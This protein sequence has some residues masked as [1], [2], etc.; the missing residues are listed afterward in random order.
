MRIEQVYCTHCTYGTSALEQR[1][2]ELADRVLGYSARAGSLERND[3]RNDYRAIERFLYYYLPSDT[4]PDEKQRLDAANA[5]RRLFFC[6]AMGKLQMVGQVAY[7][8][9]DTAG[10]LGSYFA[11]VL[12][13]DKS[14]GAWSA[15]DCLRLWGAPWVQEESA[16]HPFK[17]PSLERLDELWAGKNSPISDDAVLG[18]LRSTPDP[19]GRASSP[20]LSDGLGRPSHDVDQVID[21]R[22]QQAAVQQ[23]IDL[24]V[25]SLQGLLAFALGRRENVL[26]VIE[27]SVAA[28]VFYGVARLLPKSLSEGLGFSTYEP[29]A[30]RLPVTL[31]ATT[32]YD[33][34]TTDV[35]ADLYRRR[36]LVINT[37]QDRLSEAGAPPGDYARFIVDKL[38]E[39]GWPT[40][41]RL[42]AGF[43]A[44]GVKRPE[45]LELLVRTHGISSQIMSSSPPADDG[46]RKSEV[47]V[48][49][50]QREVQHQLAAAPA[51]WPQLHKVIGT[52]NHLTVL[53]LVASDQMPPEVQRPAQFLL[54]KFPPEQIADLVNSPLVSRTAKVEALVA[55]ITTQSRLPEDCHLL[56]TDGPWPRTRAAENGLVSDVLVK[57]PEPVLCQLGNSLND[58]RRLA[59]FAALLDA[60]VKHGPQPALKNVIVAMIGAFGDATLVDVLAK[61]RPQIQSVCSPPEPVLAQRLGRLLYELPNHAKSFEKWLSVLSEWKASFFHPHLAERRLGEWNRF[62]SCLL[63]LREPDEAAAKGKL[64]RIKNRLRAPPRAEY[65]PLAEA[66]ARAMPRRTNE[67]DELADVAASVRIDLPQLRRR[68]ELAARQSGIS[69]NLDDGAGAPAGDN[70]LFDGPGDEVARLHQRRELQTRMTHMVRHVEERLLVYSDDLLGTRKLAVLQQIGQVLA[71]RPDFLGQG[72]Q[73]IENY[74]HNN[75]AWPA[76]VL[77][78]TGKTKHGF[79]LRRRSRNWGPYLA[80]GALAAVLVPLVGYFAFGGRG[81]T[82]TVAQK[83][84]DGAAKPIVEKK[85]AVA[86]SGTD[87]VEVNPPK[88]VEPRVRKPKPALPPADKA[89]IAEQPPL[90][91]PTKPAAST[92]ENAS[93]DA[94]QASEEENGSA[95]A[96]SSDKPST[97]PMKEGT[98]SA[99]APMNNPSST[100]APS[101]DKEPAKTADEKATAETPS[102]AVQPSG[103]A[104]AV[105]KDDPVHV[106][107]QSLTLPLPG[108]AFLE[109]LSLKKWSADPGPITLALKGIAAANDRLGSKYSI[110]TEPRSEGLAIAMRVANAGDG[111]P[112]IL[113]MLTTRDGELSFQ[114]ME[115]G[116]LPQSATEARPELRRCVVEATTEKGVSYLSLA[117]PIRREPL[118][119][120]VGTARL[121]LRP[122]KSAEFEFNDDDDLYLERG[123]VEL[124]DGRQL[125]FGDRNQVVK[126]A[127]LDRLPSDCSD[128]QAQVSL[129]ANNKNPLSVQLNLS[130]DT[131]LP[132]ELKRL[133]ADEQKTRDLLEKHLQKLKASF[134]KQRWWEQTK[135]MADVDLSI[136][137]IG[138]ALKVDEF[139]TLGGKPPPAKPK[140]FENEVRTAI[141]DPGTE[142]RDQ[143]A[144]RQGA[145]DAFQQRRQ[146]QFKELVRRVVKIAVTI[147]RRV[148]ADTFAPCLMLGDP[149]QFRQLPDMTVPVFQVDDQDE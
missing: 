141:I 21:P 134:G 74:F 20:S 82:A 89:P 67:L 132:D 100:D 129:S 69:V 51:G 43:E 99:E 110:L 63:A 12:F 37:F 47:A 116:S 31:A 143:F 18:F 16:E 135:V 42:L 117:S 32:F 120:A 127:R 93:G 73:M 124:F 77:L 123:Y 55:Y 53:E 144:E 24:V 106:V 142:L 130:E 50:L 13:G 87:A 107:H 78:S 58:E 90:S 8:Q 17:L 23:R 56:A 46:W 57:L 59:F 98:P 136:K 140:E 25:N 112:S 128:A 146:G 115:A 30:E 95:P 29:N 35:R 133:S 81:S 27:P 19:T 119:M 149:S 64:D 38:L 49:Y 147:Y 65:K 72:R 26:L 1:E 109:R 61:H 92:K 40:V 94:S 118:G 52:P 41:D 122:I 126:T 39:E 131:R 108:P 70:E 2:G 125:P 113:A 76:G 121:E 7:R 60:G 105:S 9:Y 71:G 103:D 68:L 14:Q 145:V 54:K 101:A 5:P 6:P 88:A 114:W 75:G 138:R 86:K 10:R 111:G 4:P 84:V 79:K 33:P 45:D 83:P 22:W 137:S 11:H 97:T 85:Q 28:L 66:L 3:L 15:V 48:R 80:V 139:P 44:A 62:R 96:G 34:F 148:D 36:G 91:K 102:T 104:S